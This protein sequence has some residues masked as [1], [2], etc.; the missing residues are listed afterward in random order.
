[1]LIGTPFILH[2]K[3]III[4]CKRTGKWP[5]ANTVRTVAFIQSLLL[6]IRVTYY[7]KLLINKEVARYLSP[8]CKAVIRFLITVLDS[9][10]WRCSTLIFLLLSLRAIV[11]L[12]VLY[13]FL[14]KTRLFS[15]TCEHFNTFKLILVNIYE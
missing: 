12:I 7:R 4:R 11:F 14:N 2:L 5:L 6:N 9:I 1:M 10:L 15:I 13:I 8:T 3:L